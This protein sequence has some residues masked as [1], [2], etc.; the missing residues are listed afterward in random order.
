MSVIVMLRSIYYL[1]ITLLS[2]L[3]LVVAGAAQAKADG[4]VGYRNDTNQVI[5]VQSSI[6]VNNSVKKSK[7]QMLYPGEVALDSLNGP[8]TR[9]ITIHDPKKPNSP[10]LDEDVIV[11]TDMF[12]SIQVEKSDT[13]PVKNPPTTKIKLVQAALPTM[14]KQPVS[15]TPMPPNPMMPKTGSGTPKKP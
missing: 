9:H 12:F 11:K 3:A 14:P 4:L 2:S 5:V 8:G 7:P 1:S 10:L 13:V 15:P 6:T